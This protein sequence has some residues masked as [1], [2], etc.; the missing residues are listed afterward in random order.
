MS[1]NK[2]A[3]L[4]PYYERARD[5]LNYNHESGVFTRFVKSSGSYKIVGYRDSKGYIQIGLSLN[6]KMKLLRAHRI[7]WFI[8]YGELPNVIDHVDRNPSNN[9]IKNLRSCTHQQNNFN[10]GRQSNNTSGYRGVVWNV[11]VKKWQSQIKLNGN[12]IYLGLF[13]CPKEAFD[14]YNTRAKELFGEYYSNIN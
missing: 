10:T 12:R 14:V 2:N 3:E 13:N 11:R 5:I 6:S 1:I 4:L 8:Y 7:A 9:S